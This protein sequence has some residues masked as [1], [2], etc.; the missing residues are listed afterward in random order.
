MQILLIDDQPLFG[1]GF[2]QALGHGR[3]SG[4]VRSVST[5]AQGL[6]AA[7]AWA[8]LDVVLIHH[9][10]DG[11]DSLPGLR[12]FGASYPR[13]ARVLIAAEQDPALVGRAR[14]AGAAAVLDKSMTAFA[15]G[16]ALEQVCR[17]GMSFPP[18]PAAPTGGPGLTTRQRQVLGL[19]AS[20]RQHKQI[21]FELGISDRT[22]KL[23]VTA[24][25]G[26]TGA[27]NR[28]HLLVRAQALGWL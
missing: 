14:A 20:G 5:L 27:R 28:T 17:G 3:A 10:L 2:V 1:L 22:V 18:A 11:E 16:V 9:R 23:H 6:Q 4:A 12:R 24:L 25:L 21:G 19:V 8:T 7:A 13:V 15:L 26:A